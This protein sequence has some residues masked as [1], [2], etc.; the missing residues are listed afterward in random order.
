MISFEKKIDLL[1]SFIKKRVTSNLSFFVSIRLRLS[2]QPLQFQSKKIKIFNN[3]D[4]LIN[5]QKQQHS[6]SPSTIFVMSKIE[7]E[8]DFFEQN[9]KTKKSF[10]QKKI[11]FV[12]VITNSS[13]STNNSSINDEKIT[14][15]S[16]FTNAQHEKMMNM[17]TTIF[18]RFHQS[19]SISSSKHN[20]I[21]NMM[22]DS[23]LN[24]KE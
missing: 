8:S 23:I 7:F 9:F 10:E 14:L 13:N 20:L 17:F 4:V 22:I 3:D 1:N 18:R 11:E 19:K 24:H 5:I 6:T 16:N 12:D 2:N 21:E 15:R